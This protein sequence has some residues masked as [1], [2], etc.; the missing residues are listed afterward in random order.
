MQLSTRPA[1]EDAVARK[2]TSTSLRPRREAAASPLDDDCLRRM[3]G[4][5]PVALAV[6]APFTPRTAC[7]ALRKA[8]C[9][10]A[11]AGA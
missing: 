6:F 9:S 5:R 3:S 4:A 2:K 7:R 1:P 8:A 10:A 11:A